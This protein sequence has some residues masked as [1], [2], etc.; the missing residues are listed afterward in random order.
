MRFVP[1]ASTTLQVPETTDGP[2]S[3]GKINGFDEQAFLN[4]LTSDQVDFNREG[5]TEE[6]REA[7]KLELMVD[8]KY[9]ELDRFSPGVDIALGPA[10]Q[11]LETSTRKDATPRPQLELPRS[12]D[13]ASEPWFSMYV[14]GDAY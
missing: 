2:K 12:K 9:Q 11:V 8:G 4:S 13:V 1:P 14:S 7:T 10:V 6:D 5:M 3:P